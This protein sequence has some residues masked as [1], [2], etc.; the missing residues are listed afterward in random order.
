MDIAPQ[1][2]KHSK[3]VFFGGNWT[4]VNLKDSLKD[5]S[6]QQ[7]TAKLC[8]FNTI[9]ALVYHIDYYVVA[10][11]SVLQGEPLTASDKYSFDHPPVQSEEEWNS[12]LEKLWSDAE[13][14]AELVE[15]LPER[16]LLETFSEEK[17][18]N[19]YRNFQG[20]IEH[21]HYHLGQIVLIKKLLLNSEAINKN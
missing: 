19:Y 18:G 3:E 20:V 21:T 6:W 13:K 12:L 4:D 10:I 5:V 1:L 14:F 15:E 16:K 17:Y 2:A 11:L 9:A 7:A 8:S